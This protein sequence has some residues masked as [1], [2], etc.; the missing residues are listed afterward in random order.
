[1]PLN[2]HKLDCER[3]PEC[4]ITCVIQVDLGG[5]LS[6]S[7]WNRPV[8]SFLG[9]NEAFMKRI[10]M[11]LMLIKDQVEY[12]RYSLPPFTLHAQPATNVSAPSVSETR[13]YKHT[14]TATSLMRSHRDKYWTRDNAA[15]KMCT[16]VARDAGGIQAQQSFRSSEVNQNNQELST[17]GPTDTTPSTQDQGRDPSL[18][19]ASLDLGRTLSLE[20][21]ST[22]FLQRMRDLASLDMRFWSELHVPGAD[23]PFNV[24]GPTY[25]KDRRKIPAGESVFCLSAVELLVLEKPEHRFHVARFIPSVRQ[26]GAPFSLVLS[27]VM[28]GTPLLTMV[29]IFSIE[30]HPD[31]MG[32]P[33]LRPME[34][35]HDWQPFDFALHRF[36]NG[37]DEERDNTMK[38]IPHIAQG[39]WVVKQSVGTVPV[40]VGR[41]LATKYFRTS[42]YLEMDVD[43]S[44]NPTANFIT[45]KVRTC[46]KTL[47]VDMGFVLEGKTAWELPEV[48]IGAVRLPFVDLSV[49]KHIDMS[50]ELPMTP[51]S[52]SRTTGNGSLAGGSGE[53]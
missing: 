9:F 34:D 47:A 46:T 41:K 35:N 30:R 33:P 6:P 23:H 1:M 32:P 7:G 51:P 21:T 49:A 40:I 43:I 20:G 31:T 14:R 26:G 50:Q 24:R 4:L 18:D 2:S 44:A 17:Q 45:G 22:T 10:L 13:V 36:L 29:F 16:R 15:A 27:W 11:S 25:L 42:R 8:V 3:S 48:L 39:S 37:T 52:P 12:R 5:L 28:P 53:S 19:L 38:M